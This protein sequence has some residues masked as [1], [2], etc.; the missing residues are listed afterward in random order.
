MTT[1]PDAPITLAAPAT[2]PHTK[3][4][5]H[6]AKTALLTLKGELGTAPH[7]GRRLAV[8]RCAASLG[9][10]VQACYRHLEALGY[11]SGRKRRSDAG[12]TRVAGHTLQAIATA[13]R[14]GVRANGKG[15]VTTA[16]AMNVLDANG[17]EITVSES[18][19]NTLLRAKGLDKAADGEIRTTRA[20][21]SLHPNHVHQIDPSLCLLYYMGGKQVMIRDD[22]LYK[23]KLPKLAAIKLKVWRYVRYDH[24]SGTLD[25]RYYEAEGE[26]Q[27]SVFEFLNYT[28]AQQPGRVSYGVPKM[29]VWDKGSANMAQGVQ[30]LLDGLG[31]QHD[32]HA[33]GHSWAKGGVE[34]GNN[35]VEL[36]FESRLRFEPVQTCEQLNDAASAWC[37][38]YNSNSLKHIDAQLEREGGKYVRTELWLKIK[39]DELVLMPERKVCAAFMA[40]AEASRVVGSDL[41]ISYRHPQADSSATYDLAAWAKDLSPKDKVAVWPMLLGDM[42]VRVELQ[43]MGQDPLVMTVLPRTE[44]D[45][46]GRSM[47]ATVYGTYEARPRSR[48]DTLKTEL[49]QAAYG[50]HS[51]GAAITAA[52]AQALRKKG[53]APMQHK[54]ADG[55]HTPLVAHSYLRDVAVPAYLPKRD[56]GEVATP[57][58]QKARSL[59]Q[60]AAV[61]VPVADVCAVLKRQLGDSYD[62]GTYGWL[63][64]R[65]PDGFVPEDQ[66]EALRS[67]LLAGL[68]LEEDQSTPAAT[69]THDST[70]NVVSLASRRGA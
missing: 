40:G 23:N 49:D 2:M 55:K 30:R 5:S 7:G 29:L 11:D 50:S 34:G 24:A 46:Y 42:S 38:A 26:N 19:I 27:R 22:E 60:G 69:G 52:D 59:A 37:A 48:T 3:D 65:W 62:K 41:C 64:Q 61:R 25:V 6:D 44:H 14:E 21:R 15:V 17:H 39:Q 9:M 47:D 32:T 51:D 63:T 66:A 43:R 33:A 56:A 20:M 45:E 28:W 57:G 67:R 70:A 4:L 53:V 58:V 31:V 68:G 36:G 54:G 10:S 16:L 12:N 13:K 18:R 1:K 8:E 35:I